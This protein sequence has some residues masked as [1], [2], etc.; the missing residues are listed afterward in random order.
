MDGCSSNGWPLDDRSD[1][2]SDGGD[3][4]AEEQFARSQEQ[5]P[6]GQFLSDQCLNDQCVSNQCL[7][8]DG[9]DLV[10]MAWNVLMQPPDVDPSLAMNLSRIG[11]PRNVVDMVPDRRQLVWKDPDA[12]EDDDDGRPPLVA[13]DS[14][15]D[16]LLEDDNCQSSSGLASTMRH[17]GDDVGSDVEGYDTDEEIIF[18]DWSSQEKAVAEVNARGCWE[19]RLGCLTQ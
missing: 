13:D 3:V 2:G 4:E 7:T 17:H 14:S 12:S 8:R 1:G 9:E 11:R 10:E 5:E 15:D 19:C 6:S 16:E 18:S